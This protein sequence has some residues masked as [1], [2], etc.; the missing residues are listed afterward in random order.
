ML[1][2]FTFMDA[3]PGRPYGKDE[4]FDVVVQ[5]DIMFNQ[6]IAKKIYSPQGHLLAYNS[7]CRPFLEY[8]DTVWWL[9]LAYAVQSYICSR[10]QGDH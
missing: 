8:I 6:P 5:F 1:V 9:I 7:L 10:Q 4:H 2:Y 3:C